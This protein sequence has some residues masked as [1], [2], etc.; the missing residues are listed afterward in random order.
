MSFSNT[1]ETAINTYIFIGTDVSWNGNANLYFALF[2]ADPG[3]AG[4]AVT[5]EVAY[6]NYA[7]VAGVRATDFTVSGATVSNAVQVQF[8]TCG[9]TGAT[10]THAGIVSSSAGAGTLIVSGALSASQT[11]S[12]NGTPQFAIGDF[13]FTLD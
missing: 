4:S 12:Q 3:E 9:V 13:V 6:T 5:N 2:S 11:I 7:R 10:A 1:A 8:P